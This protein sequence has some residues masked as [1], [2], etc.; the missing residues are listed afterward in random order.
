[1]LDA[2]LPLPPEA[3]AAHVGVAGIGPEVAAALHD[4][5]SEPHNRDLVADLVA[6]VR[7]APVRLETRASPIAGKTLVFTGTLSA[8]G[9]DEARARAEALGAR[10][11]GSVS[12]K[13]DLVVAGADA[14]SKRARA[15][16]LGIEVMDEAA[17]LALAGV[18]TGP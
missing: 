4:F 2:L 13:T 1:M 8:M 6:E 18:Q 10:V 9:R 16:A 17:W 3:W 15:E 7:P 14:G 12:A 11:A 5:W